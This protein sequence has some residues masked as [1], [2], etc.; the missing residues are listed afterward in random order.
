MQVLQVWKDQGST[1]VETIIAVCSWDIIRN[2][3]DGRFCSIGVSMGSVSMMQAS[4]SNLEL[5]QACDKY[6]L[7]TF[8]SSHRQLS[9]PVSHMIT[10]FVATQVSR[11]PT[12]C[13]FYPKMIVLTVC[14]CRLWYLPCLGH[15]TSRSTITAA[16]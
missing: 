10:R 11:L 7:Q 3:L 4:R 2:A 12:T 5:V 8:S 13:S 14:F 9:C 16:P 1:T 6:V 15:Q